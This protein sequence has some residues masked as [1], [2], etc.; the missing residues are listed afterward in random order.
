MRPERHSDRKQFS[1]RLDSLVAAPK[2]CPATRVFLVQNTRRKL[3]LT[4]FAAGSFLAE[5]VLMTSQSVAQV[6]PFEYQVMKLK[7][8]SA[9]FEREKNEQLYHQET[10]NSRVAAY[11]SELLR[12]VSEFQK[13]IADQHQHFV[14][15][16][17]CRQLTKQMSELSKKI[18]RGV[19]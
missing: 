1:S 5:S 17:T 12:V 11:N 13:H 15:C 16:K 2:S 14:S 19:R 3:L 18:E 9:R 4:L 10:E 7:A 8:E 6:S